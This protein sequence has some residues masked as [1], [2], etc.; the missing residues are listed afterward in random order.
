MGSCEVYILIMIY[1]GIVGS[2]K[3]QPLPL[4]NGVVN[5]VHNILDRYNPKDTTIVSGGADG[6]DI[7]AVGVAKLHGYNVIEYKPK[8]YGW[9]YYRER[10]L[11][12]ANKCDKV[13]SIALPIDFRRVISNGIKCYHCAK[14]GRDDNHYKTAGCW[15]DNQC[16]EH[17]VL[18]A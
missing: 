6:V 16:K 11:L 2:S 9:V 14:I 10:N 4:S 8:G 15:T 12:I 17:E 5:A 18:V 13:Y 1:I 3:A 7:I